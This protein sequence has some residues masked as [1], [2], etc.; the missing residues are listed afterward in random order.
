M[1]TA[2]K[3][4]SQRRIGGHA[5]KAHYSVSHI[6]DGHGGTLC[7]AGPQEYARTGRGGAVVCLWCTWIND[8]AE[9]RIARAA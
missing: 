4:N 9:A 5:W 1:A 2:R 3:Y 7:P 8:A 6:T